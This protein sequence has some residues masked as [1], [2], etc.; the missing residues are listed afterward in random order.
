MSFRN[1]CGVAVSSQKKIKLV[2]DERGLETTAHKKIMLIIIGYF[3][4]SVPL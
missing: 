4:Q 2:S 1:A 3:P